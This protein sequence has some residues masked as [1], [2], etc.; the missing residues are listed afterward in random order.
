MLLLRRHGFSG[1]QSQNRTKGYRQDME[2]LGNIEALMLAF[3]QLVQC[4]KGVGGSG[5]ERE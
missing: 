2:A 5:V 3:L 4:V 1:R